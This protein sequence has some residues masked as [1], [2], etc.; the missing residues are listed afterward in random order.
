VRRAK[1]YVFG[2]C[3]S[4]PATFA[5]AGSNRSD[6]G[7]NEIVE[8]LDGRCRVAAPQ[9][10]RIRLAPGR[11]SLA[12]S[13]RPSLRLAPNRST[14]SGG[15]TQRR[16]V[17]AHAQRILSRGDAKSVRGHQLKRSYRAWRSRLTI[18]PAWHWQKWQ[19]WPCAMPQAHARMGFNLQIHFCH[20][21]RPKVAKLARTR[22]VCSQP[23]AL[24]AAVVA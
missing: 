12:P 16:C 18:S 4:H 7:S 6:D 20:F 23:R 14:R 15:D 2:G 10:P 3:D 8:A 11:D 17:C 9:V 13:K 19:K 1:A 5:P 22:L 24:T 21:Q